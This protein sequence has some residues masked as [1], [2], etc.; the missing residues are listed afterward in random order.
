MKGLVLLVQQ[1]LS[2]GN[3]QDWQDHLAEWA[4]G[5]LMTTLLWVSAIVIPLWLVSAIAPWPW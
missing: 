3:A 1:G 2:F 4:S 5:P